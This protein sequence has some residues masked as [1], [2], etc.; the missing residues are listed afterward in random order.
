MRDAI[1]IQGAREHN[2]RG[3][4]VELPRNALVVIC[5]VSG[6]GKSSLALGTLA[7]EGRRR[8]L[9]TVGEWSE[10]RPAVDLVSGVPPT[11]T[12]EQ[13][14]R[15][16]DANELVSG[17]LEVH[18]GL[19]LLWAETGIVHCATCGRPLPV[20]DR[21]TIART[22]AAE[23]EGT[24]LT[25]MAPVLRGGDVGAVALEIA[26]QGFVRVRWNGEARRLDEE[27]LGGS[28]DLDVIV[29]RISTGEGK[30]SRIE[31]AIA[32]ALAAGRGR[33]L[34]DVGGVERAFAD[35]PY[36]AVDDRSYENPTTAALSYRSPVGACAT[37]KGSGRVEDLP[38]P[39]CS[40]TRLGELS[41]M[42]RVDGRS[43]HDMLLAPLGAVEL[44]T[45]APRLEPV[46]AEI[47]GRL[48]Q[49]TAL[50]LAGLPL[51][52]PLGVVSATEWTR[53]RLAAL[54]GAELAGVLYVLD[55]PTD[56]LDAG[57]T[58][59]VLDALRAT[60]ERG[61]SIVVVGHDPAVVRAAEHVVELGPG[62][63]REGGAVVFQGTAAALVKAD[64]ATGR[65]LR[66]E[67]PPPHRARKP[68]ARF[69]V[70]LAPLRNLR[71]ASASVG[72]G[73]HTVVTGPAGAGKTA[74][75]SALTDAVRR[76]GHARLLELPETRLGQS[77]A[78][79]VAT[80]AR[81]WNGV[82]TLLAETR[83]AKVRGFGPEHFSL[84]R[85]GGRCEVCK[86]AG[87]VAVAYEGLA[88]FETPCEVCGGKRFDRGTLRAT[89]LGVNAAE[90]LA[91]TVAQ[92]KEL[93][94]NQRR[95]SAPLASLERVGL[96]YLQLGQPSKTLS[97]GEAQRIRL[98]RELAT[99][100]DLQGTMAILDA[101]SSGLHPE[102]T[103]RLL[104]VLDGL[105]D[106]GMT[107]VS[108]EV[109]ALVLARADEVVA[110]A[111]G[112][113]MGAADR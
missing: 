36:C 102:D 18:D 35:H 69:E 11:V 52:R 80:A 31:E 99:G 4:D 106:A 85:P 5:G 82:R 7:Q 46:R 60:R 43:F 92:A 100:G 40:G 14:R 2:L 86:G 32:T 104:D 110:L 72:L 24:R 9:Q 109:N 71:V 103:A 97:G 88:R 16:P 54:L 96:G 83:E 8:F 81:V 68:R 87:A 1:R 63:G 19:A 20:S 79:C 28:G 15:G 112:A 39:T 107:L 73:I 23:P 65:S 90:I 95:I 64:T 61:N 66:Q 74:F 37:C 77:L 53:A 34:V 13:S 3:V 89:F 50:G 57:T 44:P 30:A 58:A 76:T 101:P 98:A 67:H 6:S 45:V 113:T 91:M 108:A 22:L 38:C 56:G 33:A 55:E 41:R 105:V 10:P 111:A 21:E 70:P 62:A 75:S 42:L 59:A 49:A 93:F 29:D 12:L 51:G 94:Q 48:A 26:R 78:S 47:V 17:C 25:V 84:H 27:T